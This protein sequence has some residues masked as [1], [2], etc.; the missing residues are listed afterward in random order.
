MK[1]LYP[2]NF[3]IKLCC[4]YHCIYAKTTLTCYNNEIRQRDERM[5]NND[6]NNKGNKKKRENYAIIGDVHGMLE[7]LEKL[8]QKLGFS[9]QQGVYQHTDT[10]AIFAGDLV[11]RGK[12]QRGVLELVMAMVEQ[13]SAIAIM[14][15]HE[16]NVI[17]FYSINPRTQKPFIKHNLHNQ[18]QR[19]AI[20]NDYPLAGKDTE[21]MINWLKSLPLFLRLDGLRVVHAT[22]SEQ[23]IER[24]QHATNSQGQLNTNAWQ[25]ALTEG[26]YLQT[27]IRMLLKGAGIPPSKDLKPE[28]HNTR[29]RK[30]YRISWW[31]KDPS[32]WNN[33]LCS[34]RDAKVFADTPLPTHF[35]FDDP[36]NEERPSLFFGHYW[37]KGTP[38][39][40]TRNLACV[41]YSACRGGRLTAYVWRKAD[42]PN[43]KGLHA[44]HFVSVP[45]TNFR[46]EECQN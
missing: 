31:N 15:N 10:I 37:F 21:E 42:N 7:P 36:Y 20:L 22:W 35:P 18:K 2:L 9:Q 19:H 8:L 32:N 44:D 34:P 4:C 28:Q 17:S 27:A 41:D 25:E 1:F 39:P 33:I 3:N 46:E 23:M 26:T 11:D 43:E 16:Y 14:G 6:I 30:W 5:E 45:S 40:L 12:H 29:L 13:G 24:L 38:K